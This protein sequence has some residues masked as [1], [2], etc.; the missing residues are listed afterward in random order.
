MEKQ[1]KEQVK[2]GGIEGTWLSPN[3]MRPT[4][5]SQERPP[6]ALSLL[7]VKKPRPLMG[8]ALSGD[9]SGVDISRGVEKLE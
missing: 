9:R 2:G 7:P 1:Q 4:P 6:A 5:C 8:F 3:V